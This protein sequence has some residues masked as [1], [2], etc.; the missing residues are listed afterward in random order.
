[1][2][3]LGSQQ[4]QSRAV[5]VHAVK[6]G[7]IDEPVWRTAAPREEYLPCMLIDEADLLDR[8]RPVGHPVLEVTLPV[9]PIE[10]APAIAPRKPKHGATVLGDIPDDI[11][12]IR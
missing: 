12:Q 3:I 1:M 8:P 9:E 7:M 5:E 10:M 6:V 11:D 2:C 4:F